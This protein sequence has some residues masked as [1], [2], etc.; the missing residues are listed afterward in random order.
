MSANAFVD[1]ARDQWADA[2]K[3]SEFYKESKSGQHCGKCPQCGGDNR[4]WITYKGEKASRFGCRICDPAPGTPQAAE[5]ARALNDLAGV[6]SSPSK[7]KILRTHEYRTSKG[8]VRHVKAIPPDKTKPTTF[9]QHRDGTKWKRTMGPSVKIRDLLWNHW[10]VREDHEIC[11]VCEGEKDA[12]LLQELLKSEMPDI[13]FVSGAGG[14]GNPAMNL[15]PLVHIKKFYV[16]FD[17]DE[18]GRKGAPKYAANIQKTYPTA[19]V[20]YYAAR[21]DT[22]EDWG[23]IIKRV[24]EKESDRGRVTALVRERLVE[25]MTKASLFTSDS[26]PSTAT[27]P[28]N[29]T[30]NGEVGEYDDLTIPMGWTDAEIAAWILKNKLG[31]RI[32]KGL[33]VDAPVIYDQSRGEWYFCRGGVWKQIDF[34][35]VVAGFMEEAREVVARDW[36]GDKEKLLKVLAS[37]VKRDQVLK[38]IQRYV[39][40]RG[41]K[42]FDQSPWLVCGSAPD[43]S[44]RTILRDPAGKNVSCPAQ[45]WDLRTGQLRSAELGDYIRS[46]LGTPLPGQPLVD[47][48]E[49]DADTLGLHIAKD[50]PEFW[51]LIGQISSYIPNADTPGAKPE[52]D[53]S[54][55][56]HMCEWIGQCLTAD[57]T[58]EKFLFWKGDGS[59]GKGLLAE[60]LLE[61]TGTLG[62]VA[63]D[64]LFSPRR[65][66]HRQEQA[67]LEGKHLLVVDEQKAHIDIGLL[68]SWTGGMPI[69]A[70]HKG[71]KSITFPVTFSVILLSNEMPR[72][73]SANESMRRRLVGVPFDMVFKNRGGHFPIRAK[74]DIFRSI[75]REF[76]RL[77]YFCLAMYRGVK[78]RGNQFTPCA[79]VD[80]KSTELLLS[81]N[82]VQEWIETC[83]HVGPEFHEVATKDMYASYKAFMKENAYRPVLQ[84]KTFTAEVRSVTL[85]KSLDM[86][87]TSV[88]PREKRVRGFRGC[89]L[90]ATGVNEPLGNH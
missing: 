48:S 79:R 64:G 35:K 8:D 37:H 60:I 11:V 30:T 49:K 82:R 28:V 58:P 31:A 65:T 55:M 50:C 71:G 34:P 62:H 47:A 33:C 76:P 23:D 86:V 42:V 22:G 13:C 54:W 75:R 9:W 18:G 72:F 20:C 44:T 4:F 17:A 69:T 63:P 88:G 74:E 12:T 83:L 21:G 80:A 14:S 25:V 40:E 85:Q 29:G 89:A 52:S 19:K 68:K 16:L 67:I 3:N 43:F 26:R 56:I 24:Q 90:K 78:L 87:Y 27:A 66:A 70:D 53:H 77:A 38:I 81:M 6:R 15:A 45:I 39:N 59:N 61:L 2:Y 5:I 36:P 32:E 84:S 41:E 1:S 73:P 51:R 57:I 46:T 7:W 10:T